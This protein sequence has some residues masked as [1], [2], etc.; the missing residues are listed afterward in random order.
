VKFGLEGNFC[1]RDLNVSRLP[2]RETLANFS[3]LSLYL[4]QIPR[5]VLGIN[6]RFIVYRY[7]VTAPFYLFHNTIHDAQD[8]NLVFK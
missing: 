2:G 3:F 4:P 1:P 6:S 7:I 8:T 5:K